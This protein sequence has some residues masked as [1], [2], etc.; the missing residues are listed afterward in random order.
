DAAHPPVERVPGSAA[1]V[2]DHEEWGERAR[3]VFLA[4]AAA[5]VLARLLAARGWARPLAFASAGL[6]LVGAFLLYEAAEHG[7]ELVYSYAGGVGIRTGD[8]QDVRRLTLAAAHHQAELD[9][10]EGRPQDAASITAEAAKR[11]PDDPAVQVMAAESQLRDLG[12]AKGALAT[13]QR[14]SVPPSD[15]RL[16]S[17]HGLLLAELQE[18]TG[19]LEGARATLRQL[20]QAFPQNPRIRQK[21]DALPPVAEP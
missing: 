21:L 5:E 4:V 1:A 2:K 15:A 12:D 20:A 10:K 3:N 18:K 19:D 16:R 17:R 8:P 7:G 13:V 14:V 6:C 9:R 11:F